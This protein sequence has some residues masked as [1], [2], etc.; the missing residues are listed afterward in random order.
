MEEITTRTPA[1]F[2]DER[3]RFWKRYAP[4]CLAILILTTLFLCE[5]FIVK[6]NTEVKVW[7]EASELYEQKLEAYKAEQARAVQEEYFLSGDA[8]R[9]SFI[10]QEIDAVAKVIA[11]LSTDDQKLTEASCMLARVMNSS[12]PD[13]FADVASQSSQW[14]FYDGTNTSFSTH[15][16][17]LAES[18][19]RPYHESGIVPNGLTSAY[20][21]GEWSTSDFVLRDTWE[22]TSR[23]H[24]WRYS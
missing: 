10:N 1:H 14:M 6:H 16:R 15:D 12:Y 4:T 24:Y 17:E 19:V 20:V 22:R 18:I 23:S 7:A 5:G 8:S 2:T 9:E 11:R 13:N 21:Y 3:V